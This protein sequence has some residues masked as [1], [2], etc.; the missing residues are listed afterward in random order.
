[1]DI[2]FIY[3]YPKQYQSYLINVCTH[4]TELSSKQVVL[5]IVYLNKG[6]NHRQLIVTKVF[7]V[8]L[9]QFLLFCN[10]ARQQIVTFSFLHHQREVR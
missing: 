6:K 5:C 2:F 7:C 9:V 8:E 10:F 1:M 4:A 3:N